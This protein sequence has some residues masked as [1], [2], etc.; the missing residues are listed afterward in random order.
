MTT[1]ENASFL[2]LLSSLSL[3]VCCLTPQ[4]RSRIQIAA[5]AAPAAAPAA[6]LFVSY[7]RF[8][9]ACTFLSIFLAHP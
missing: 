8:A 6:A 7:V 4:G 3:L 9:G 1:G 2:L 5:V